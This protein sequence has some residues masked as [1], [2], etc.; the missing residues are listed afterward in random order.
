MTLQPG[1]C[2]RRRVLSP[3]PRNGHSR[4]VCLLL[5]R[6]FEPKFAHT[7]SLAKILTVHDLLLTPPSVISK[8]S[9][10]PP[11]EVQQIVQVV[12]K[13]SFSPPRLLRDVKRQSDEKI[14]TG[15][16]ALDHALGGGFRTGMLWEIVGERLACCTSLTSTAQ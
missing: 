16:A 6:H 4:R 3:A 9:R 2:F 7:R 11:F 8:Q 12:C 5:Q 15:D 1:K 14:T 10:L 13:E